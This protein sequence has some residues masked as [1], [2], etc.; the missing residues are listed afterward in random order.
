MTCRWK[1]GEALA[2]SCGRGRADT[3]S[4]AVSVGRGIEL[5]MFE[6]SFDKWHLG[7][8]RLIDF[9]AITA[10]LVRFQFLVKPLAVRPL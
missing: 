2:D 4:P 5:G 7:V 1:R 9:A 6:V 8:V 3:A 10:L